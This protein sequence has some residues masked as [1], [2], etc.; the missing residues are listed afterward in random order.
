MKPKGLLLPLT[1]G[2]VPPSGGP[3]TK[4]GGGLRGLRV[5][6]MYVPIEQILP[7]KYPREELP[8]QEELEELEKSIK[9]K[10]IIVPIVVVQ[11]KGKLRVVDGYLRYMTAKKLQIKKIPVRKIKVKSDE[12]ELIISLTANIQQKTETAASIAI[13]VYKLLEMVRNKFD[14]Q[15]LAVRHL[16]KQLG[17]S[18]SWVN[19]KLQLFKQITQLKQKGVSEKAIEK[20]DTQTVQIVSKAPED[21]IKQ[22]VKDLEEGKITTKEAK[23]KV[24]QAISKHKEIEK[25]L[26]EQRKLIDNIKK[27]EREIAE[28]ESFNFEEINKQIIALDKELRKLKK[29]RDV[30]EVLAFIKEELEPRRARKEQLVSEKQELLQFFVEKEKEILSVQ[31]E[32]DKLVNEKEKVEKEIK[33]LEEK[34][35]DLK[36][37]K[38]ELEEKLR[39]KK[40]F[41]SEVDK[42]NKRITEIGRE[43]ERLQKEIE[44]KEAHL[45]VKLTKRNIKSEEELLQDIPED[46]IEKIDSLLEEKRK[47]KNLRKTMR[48]KKSSL[49]DKKRN[50][51]KLKKQLEKLSS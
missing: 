35:N 47:L 26:E 5:V 38:Q 29:Q 14:K 13:R 16:A 18:E 23:K 24:T 3:E 11:E 32:A 12:E 4:R 15:F 42:K 1:K 28:I 44:N 43:L 8:S 34:L 37:K 9:E 25:K 10:G 22:V 6:V 49:S 46:V 48:S 31:R 45:N 30:A 20:M 41:L 33:E 50:L 40:E 27:L 2:T 36:A 39:D 17:K 19:Q 21:E 7:P 51:Q